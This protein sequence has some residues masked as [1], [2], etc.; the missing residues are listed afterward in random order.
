MSREQE[1]I[2]DR[3]C[4]V[5]KKEFYMT[6]YELINHSMLCKRVMEAGLVMPGIE[7]GHEPVL[8]VPGGRRWD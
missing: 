2:K 8:I 5:C 7:I 1:V 4:R 6:S 3:S